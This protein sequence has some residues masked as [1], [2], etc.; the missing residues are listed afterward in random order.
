M[1]LRLERWVVD[2]SAWCGSRGDCSWTE[3]RQGFYLVWLCDTSRSTSL[4]QLNLCQKQR[5]PANDR[6]SWMISACGS[7]LS[8]HCTGTSH[9]SPRTYF[10]ICAVYTQFVDNSALMSLHDWSRLLCCRGLTTA[11]MCSPVI[12]RQHCHRCMRVL[13][14]AVRLVLDLKQREWPRWCH[15]VNAYEVT[16]GSKWLDR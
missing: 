16:A 7:N 6:C 10:S 4:G 8:C 13:N 14:A 12:Q 9:G 1:I 15:L 3:T 5:F 2:V 11:T